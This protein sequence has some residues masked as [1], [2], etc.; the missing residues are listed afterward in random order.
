MQE[1]YF[2]IICLITILPCLAY[3]GFI[4]YSNKSNYNSNSNSNSQNVTLMQD[5]GSIII[6][7]ACL[8]LLANIFIIYKKSSIKIS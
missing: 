2:N 4:I 7:M 8:M 1:L 3:L 5:I 6:F